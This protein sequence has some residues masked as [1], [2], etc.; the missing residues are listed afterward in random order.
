MAGTDEMMEWLAEQ[1]ADINAR[2]RW[3]QTPLHAMMWVT[4]Y[5]P[6]HRM[7]LLIGVGAD[8]H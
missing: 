7:E 3:G 4:K 8:F 2:D 6:L 1:G 5:E